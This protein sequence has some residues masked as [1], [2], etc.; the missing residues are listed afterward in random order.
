VKSL[1]FDTTRHGW[2][3]FAS[4]MHSRYD[5]A[6]NCFEEATGSA[7]ATDP[8]GRWPRCMSARRDSRAALQVAHWPVAVGA[9]T[10]TGV[11]TA[12]AL[13]ARR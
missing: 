1:F 4:P 5:I 6:Q 7:N 2:G 11:G 8:F 9:G 12:M 10:G 13:A 3:H